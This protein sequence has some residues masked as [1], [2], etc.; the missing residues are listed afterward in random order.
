MGFDGQSM[1]IRGDE[2]KSMKYVRFSYILASFGLGCIIL[3]FVFAY[4][5]KTMS[6]ML[7]NLSTI[8]SIVLGVVSILYTYCSGEDTIKKMN[9]ILIQY[10]NLTEHISH[11]ASKNNYDEHNLEHIKDGMNDLLCNTRD[12]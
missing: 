4:K 7:S 2:Y 9:D 11:E 3:S 12:R 5:C 6:E 1:G 10:S 8:V